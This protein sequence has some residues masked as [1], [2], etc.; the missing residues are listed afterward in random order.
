[1]ILENFSRFGDI[2]R[3]TPARRVT[4]Y[5]NN[6]WVGTDKGF[7]VG[8]RTDIRQLKTPSSWISYFPS[9]LAAGQESDLVNGLII[10]N[11]TVYIGA[12]NAVFRL[13][14]EVDTE[15][16]DLGMYGSPY[17]Y[18]MTRWGDS[19][20]V[21]C[22]RSSQFYYNQFFIELPMDFRDFDFPLCTNGKIFLFG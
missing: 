11:D 13:E 22:E 3:D 6:V 17:I 18:N 10:I 15:L 12:E 19:L 14:R 20:F 4:L 2:D 16:I 21:H 1:M 5:A 8:D 9:D 7:A